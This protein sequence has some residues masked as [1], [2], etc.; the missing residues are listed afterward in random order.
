MP[1]MRQIPER[2]LPG[3]MPVRQSP[4]QARK[5][6]PAPLPNLLS[7]LCALPN[8]VLTVVY[9]HL[10][11]CDHFA[12]C[13]YSTLLRAKVTI[14]E[15]A[16]QLFLADL[17]N[18]SVTTTDQW[19]VNVDVEAVPKAFKKRL[20]TFSKQCDFVVRVVHDGSTYR[21]EVELSGLSDPDRFRFRPAKNDR[22]RTVCLL[23]DTLL[24]GAKYH[25]FKIYKY[26]ECFEPGCGSTGRRTLN[27]QYKVCQ[28]SYSKYRLMWVTGLT[29]HQYGKLKV[30]SRCKAHVVYE[31]E[32]ERAQR[33]Y[34]YWCK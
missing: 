31:T 3:Q 4:R 10:G 17:V 9:E 5:L 29:K 19:K 16:P 28:C 20:S 24:Y 1:F 33:I 32:E 7:R 23:A 12:C 18:K 22:T 2:R 14:S 8:D 26:E 13:V 15:R 34:D 11:I 21:Q 25:K 6:C 27:G 30:W